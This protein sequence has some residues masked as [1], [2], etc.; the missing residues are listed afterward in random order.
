MTASTSQWI[1]PDSLELSI[2]KLSFRLHF[3]PKPMKSVTLKNI[4][5]CQV[6]LNKINNYILITVMI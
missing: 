1:P 4:Q 6:P 2:A 3:M 5:P